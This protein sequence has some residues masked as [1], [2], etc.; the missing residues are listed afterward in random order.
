MV[1]GK[2]RARKEDPGE[3]SSQSPPHIDHYCCYGCGDSLD[4]DEFLQ[5]LPSFHP[6]CYSGDENSFT[7]DSN[8]NFVDDSPNPPPQP[9]MYSYE[10][11]GNDA[12]YGHDFPSQVPFIYNLETCYNHDINFLQNFQR[13]S[14]HG[15]EQLNTI[16]KKESDK[17][18]KSSVEDLVPNPSMS[19]GLSNIGKDS[20]SLMEEIDSFLTSDDL[21]PPG[22]ENDDYDSEGDILVIKELLS[23]DSLSRP[24][25]ESF[26]FDVPSYPRPLTKPLD[27]R[28]YFEPNTGLLTAKVVDISEC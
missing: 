5:T 11:C 18:I 28:I 16:P 21:M 15:D 19:E 23:S 4:V 24:K 10:F 25:N 17:F 14:H 26:H 27:V 6:T 8:L 22:I 20:D 12:H 7:Y 1:Y 3:N 2:E 13:L 9:S